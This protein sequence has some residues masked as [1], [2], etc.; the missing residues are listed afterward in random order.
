MEAEE[1][2]KT[3]FNENA[4][5]TLVVV[6]SGKS[7]MLMESLVGIRSIERDLRLLN[8]QSFNK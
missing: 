6:Q 7:R 5:N 2:V 1:A 8:L 4:I 3:E